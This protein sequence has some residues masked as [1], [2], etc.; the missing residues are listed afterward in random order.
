MK[1]SIKYV[2]VI[3][4]C[5]CVLTIY[6]V[7]C[8]YLKGFL[9]ASLPLLRTISFCALPLGHKGRFFIHKRPS[10]KTGKKN[11]T[12]LSIGI[13]TEGKKGTGHLLMKFLINILLIARSRKSGRPSRFPSTVIHRPKPDSM[14]NQGYILCKILW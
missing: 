9:A 8:L 12:C 13:M 1:C 14:V 2:Y 6:L 7:L 4:I 3:A 11:L 10:I 5:V